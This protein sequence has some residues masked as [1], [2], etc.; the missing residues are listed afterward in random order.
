[1]AAILST[2]ETRD[3]QTFLDSFDQVDG[4]TSQSSYNHSLRPMQHLPQHMSESGPHGFAPIATPWSTSESPSTLDANQPH[5]KF[6]TSI[7]AKRG[8]QYIASTTETS[9]T[10]AAPYPNADPLR[11]IDD[12]MLARMAAQARELS[13]WMK[14][15]GSSNDQG[16]PVQPPPFDSYGSHSEPPLP[17][18]A[19]SFRS[20]K[21]PREETFS[22]LNSPPL[23]SRQSL[24]Y[25]ERPPAV[26]TASSESDPLRAMR[27]AE[28]RAE[29]VQRMR[30][31]NGIIPGVHSMYPHQGHH[32]D[33][34][35]SIE[36]N[37]EDVD[38]VRYEDMQA[39]QAAAVLQATQY[40]P[41]PMRRPPSKVRD[42]TAIAAARG[43]QV[44]QPAAV[45]ASSEPKVIHAVETL[46][47]TIGGD[48]WQNDE[49]EAA[50]E[51]GPAKRK[52]A[53][54][55]TR[56]KSVKATPATSR[57]KMPKTAKM[58]ATSGTAS[59][60]VDEDAEGESESGVNPPPFDT[61]ANI[62]PS[63]YRPSKPKACPAPSAQFPAPTKREKTKDKD[64][65]KDKDKGADK[66]AL[67]TTEQKKANHIASE[68]KRRAAIRQGYES[69]CVVVPPLR[70]AV[71]EFEERVKKFNGGGG[72]FSRGKKRKGSGAGAA[73]PLSGGIEIGGEKIDG[74][75][76]PK[77]EAVVLVKT[78]D[79]L[80]EVLAIRQ[81]RLERLSQLYQLAEDN[82]IPASPGRRIW[83]EVW[84]DDDVARWRA[85]HGP[86]DK[87]A[88]DVDT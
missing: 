27:E 57:V 85:A 30:Q 87:D 64:K 8:P 76:G 20:P 65:A 14:A 13:E 2:D 32:F 47:S 18:N 24:I 21:R 33:S 60:A 80:R 71:E 23:E 81:E 3:F 73:G 88:V 63:T 69:L 55:V 78:V 52:K 37:Q 67:L 61:P 79:Y 75:A 22:T 53:S 48:E 86:P 7:A 59:P 39:R 29:Y 26:A 45:S 31:A 1:M 15:R 70:A 34:A 5:P 40:Q 54:T 44:L 68:Q 28:E 51:P 46:K 66:P 50:D 56:K 38:R 10:P 9:D 58:P 82:G 12:D 4:G 77:S 19:S 62:P 25:Q 41:L 72:S 17:P 11:T 49:S 83:D 35:M 74:R 36:P 16:P 42:K 43:P 84:N 6:A